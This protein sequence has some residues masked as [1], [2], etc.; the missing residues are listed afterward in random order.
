M[1]RAATTTG[2]VPTSTS[3][4]GICLIAWNT[5]KVA[6][7][8][9]S[10]ANSRT[11]R[12]RCCFIY[13]LQLGRLFAAHR[14][15]GGHEDRREV[16]AKELPEDPERRKLL[17]HRHAHCARRE[18]AGRRLLDFNRGAADASGGQVL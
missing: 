16:A 11:I 18:P 15:A 9:V 12:V 10:R 3:R 1:L 5:A 17:E 14:G 8:A 7:P 6:I 4:T 13:V 2:T